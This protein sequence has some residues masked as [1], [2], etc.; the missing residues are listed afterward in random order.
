MAVKTA[1]IFRFLMKKITAENIKIKITDVIKKIK[2]FDF[3]FDFSL[4]S[5][6]SLESNESKSSALNSGITFF[7]AM[8]AVRQ[9]A[10]IE[11][12]SIGGRRI[13]TP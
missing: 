12:I 4:E 6:E 8:K 11:K 13:N 3:S 1:R 7:E 5:L 10:K 9:P 2:V